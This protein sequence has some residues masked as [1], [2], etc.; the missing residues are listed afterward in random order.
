MLARSH[1]PER[2]RRSLRLPHSAGQVLSVAL[3]SLHAATGARAWALNPGNYVDEISLYHSQHKA[4]SLKGPRPRL[5][6][7][8]NADDAEE[9]AL[10]ADA[11]FGFLEIVQESDPF[12]APILLY[13]AAGHLTGVYSRAFFLWD[14]DSPVHGVSVTHRARNVGTSEIRIQNRGHFPR[15]ATAVFLLT[16]APSYFSELVVYAQPPQL[17][18]GPGELLE[19]FSQTQTG[20]SPR[21]LTLDELANFDIVQKVQEVKAHFHLHKWRGI[22][23]TLFVVDLLTIFVASTIARY[24]VL[25]WR[26][27]FEGRTNSYRIFF[28]NAFER[29]MRFGFDFI[30]DSLVDPKVFWDSPGLHMSSPYIDD[31]LAKA[32]IS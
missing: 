27:I 32:V 18:T 5:R 7:N 3:G 2:R 12:V 1:V 23:P 15:V 26:R 17:H 20:N 8:L 16:G 29:F 9:M 11:G 4:L 10:K 13:Y 25:G 31:E 14:Q 28:D 22:G 19:F 24:D 30:V 21:V 6:Q